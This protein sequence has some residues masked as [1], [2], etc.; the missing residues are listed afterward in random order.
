MHECADPHLPVDT[1]MVSSW[2]RFNR[3]LSHDAKG[4]VSERIIE[5]RIE[6]AFRLAIDDIRIFWLTLARITELTVIQA[7]V[8]ADGCEFQAAGDLLVNPRLVDVFFQ[9]QAM[10]VAKNRHSGLSTQ[11]ETAMKGHDPV[12]WLAR[13]ATTR[14]KIE[15]LLP[16]L[17]QSLSSSGLINPEYLEGLGQR[18]CRVADTITF[19]LSWQIADGN[20][21]YRRMRDSGSESQVFILSNLCR[22]GNDRFEA[23]G[24]DIDKMVLKE[25]ISTRF[26]SGVT[27]DDINPSPVRNNKRQVWHLPFG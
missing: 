5:M 4:L 27:T 24:E 26:I 21:L 13:E 6:E 14:V 10:P 9:S 18:M 12:A 7:G 17:Q 16:T 19:L 11:F 2:L 20:D 8:Y 25:P 23:M 15:A 1:R 22:F 3:T